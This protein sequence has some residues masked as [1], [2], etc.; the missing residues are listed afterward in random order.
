MR[1]TLLLGMLFCII[2]LNA[3]HV[4]ERHANPNYKNLKLHV[5]VLER[6]GQSDFYKI[7]IDII[8]T[9]N[10]T[11]SF[12]ENPSS[13][14]RIFSFYAAG[15][16]FV[17]EIQRLRIEKNLKA[18]PEILKFDV[19]RSIKPKQKYTIITQIYISNRQKFRATNKNLRVCLW[20]NDADLSF[21]EDNNCP[22]IKSDNIIDFKW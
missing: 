16:I 13:Y 15:I 17:N 22:K 12:W 4:S 11:V 19:K 10:T 18:V 5:K 9:G 7:Q 8:N 1:N 20:F 2:N 21:M 3:E 14:G 6:D